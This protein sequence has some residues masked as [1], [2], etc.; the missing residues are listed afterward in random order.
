MQL[1]SQRRFERKIWNE[2]V[3]IAPLEWGEAL[4]EFFGCWCQDH[5]LEIMIDYH[6]L[7]RTIDNHLLVIM[8]DN[9]FH[10]FILLFWVHNDD[11]NLTKHTSY[12]IIWWR[13]RW[14]QCNDADVLFSSFQLW[15]KTISFTNYSL[16]NLNCITD[17]DPQNIQGMWHI[18]QPIDF[19]FGMR[20]MMWL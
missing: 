6:L 14:E 17:K 12:W 3:R 18:Y 2:N 15:K 11:N 19:I 1:D 8:I 16:S 4:L 13:P 20:Q 5:L 10:T 9:D 7:V